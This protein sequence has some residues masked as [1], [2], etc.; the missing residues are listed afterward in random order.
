[1]SKGAEAA[2]PDIRLGSEYSLP[3]LQLKVH[4]AGPGGLSGDRSMP[5]GQE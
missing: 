3:H 4:L 2:S 5:M 1:M